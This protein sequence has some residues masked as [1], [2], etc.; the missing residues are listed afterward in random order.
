MPRQKTVCH[1][2]IEADELAR[3]PGMGMVRLDQANLDDRFA[4][5]E[6]P[7]DASR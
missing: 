4:L 6:P 7:C 5:A 1:A 3:Q 2:Y